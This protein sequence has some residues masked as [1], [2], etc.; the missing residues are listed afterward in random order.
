[1]PQ[2]LWTLYFFEAQGYKIDD[3][4]L[5]QDNKSS[6][7]LETNGRE[8]SGKRMRHMAVRYSF[9]ADRV[10]SKEIRIEYCPTA[11][12]LADY[13]TKPLQGALFRKLRDMSMGNT[14]IELPTDKI[15]ADIPGGIP[16]PSPDQESRSVLDIGIQQASAL[17]TGSVSPVK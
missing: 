6:I 3:N 16:V 12:M 13:F 7:L 4:L 9:I 14:V 2:V 11:I 10:K 5:Y 17:A 8:L 1:M 15:G